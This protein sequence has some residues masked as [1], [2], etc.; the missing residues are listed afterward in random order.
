METK[1]QDLKLKPWLLSELHQRGY[2]YARD[3][4][5]LSVAQSLRIPGM[6]GRDW[7]KIA[8][9]Q[10]RESHPRASRKATRNP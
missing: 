10:G 3:T 6:G 1:L 9:A 5:H 8:D 2:I 7:R 4:A